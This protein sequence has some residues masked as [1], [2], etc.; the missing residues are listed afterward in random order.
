MDVHFRNAANKNNILNSTFYGDH[1]HRQER[2]NRPFPVTG[3]KKIRQ[4]NKL[5]FNRVLLR[6]IGVGVFL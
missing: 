1:L 5:F 3:K 4:I 2:T 6:R